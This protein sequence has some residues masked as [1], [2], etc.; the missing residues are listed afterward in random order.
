[1]SQP[2]AQE[3]QVATGALRSEG[4]IWKTEGDA[5]GVLAEK[6]AGLNRTRLEAGIFQIYI[7]PYQQVCTLVNTVLTQGD[8]AMG[9]IG[10]T[11]N[12]SADM[13]DR[14]EANNVHLAQKTW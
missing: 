6:V 12:D 5:C 1:M 8:T 2:S 9:N 10:Q 7:G 3:I 4:G 14:E 11:L 13:Y